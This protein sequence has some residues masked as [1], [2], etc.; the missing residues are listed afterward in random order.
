MLYTSGAKVPIIMAFR[1][2]KAIRRKELDE[3][4]LQ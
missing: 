2:G 1:V 4:V 3:Q